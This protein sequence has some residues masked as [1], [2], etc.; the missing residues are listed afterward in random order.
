MSKNEKGINE[1][2]FL[3]RVYRKAVWKIRYRRNQPE[4]LDV[5][6]WIYNTDGDVVY[7]T[8]AEGDELMF[9]N[10]NARV[11]YEIIK[12]KLDEE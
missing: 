1:F 3:E 2:I 11:E 8:L 5:S 4:I 9:Y 6:E 10:D 7:T 12:G